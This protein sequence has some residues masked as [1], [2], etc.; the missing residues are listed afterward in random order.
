MK[1]WCYRQCHYET[2][3]YRQ[4]QLCKVQDNLQTKEEIIR[5]TVAVL[6]FFAEKLGKIQK[7][8]K[9][10]IARTMNLF[11]GHVIQVL[12]IGYPTLDNVTTGVPNLG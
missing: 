9:F 10:E 2:Q 11:D 3:Y 1:S 12:K 7:S 4:C 6:A 8:L 5:L